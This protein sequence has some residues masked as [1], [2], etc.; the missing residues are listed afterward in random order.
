MNVVAGF[1]SE[2]ANKAVLFS[3]V[4]GR[5]SEGMDYPAEEMEILVMVGIPYPKPSAKQRALE[6]F[7]DRKFKKGWE[8]AVKA[9]TTRKLLQTIG[10]LIRDE[11][12]RGVAVILDKR[13]SHF[14][15]FIPDLK[16]SYN[17]IKDCR[18]FFS[19]AAIGN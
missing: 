2:S 6:I 11:K 10:R 4:G 7:Y 14:K 13:A 5:L 18:D 8:Y 1:K 16:L 19:K 3:V 9:P 12:D 17:I 15:N